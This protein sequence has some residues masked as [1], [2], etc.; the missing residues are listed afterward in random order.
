MDMMFSSKADLEVAVYKHK[1]SLLKNQKQKDRV[2]GCP[3]VL[4]VSKRQKHHP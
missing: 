4:A 3:L 2:Q 1:W